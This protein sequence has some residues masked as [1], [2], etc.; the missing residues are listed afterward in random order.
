M[1]LFVPSGPVCACHTPDASVAWTSGR[2]NDTAMS[3]DEDSNDFQPSIFTVPKIE[4]PCIEARLSSG[5]RRFDC[6][7]RGDPSMSA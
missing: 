5:N 7:S 6:L 4:D 2:R 1:C 3:K